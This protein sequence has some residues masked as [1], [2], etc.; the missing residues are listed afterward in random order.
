M[1]ALSI[2]REQID[3]L[4]GVPVEQTPGN[5]GTASRFEKGRRYTPNLGFRPRRFA[6]L[7]HSYVRPWGKTADGISPRAAQDAI[8]SGCRS[9]AFSQSGRLGEKTRSTIVTGCSTSNMTG[10]EA[11]AISSTVA[12]A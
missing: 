5:R 11:S 6:D 2:T 1:P 3:A 10:S 4:L 9:R 12:A 7:L 8:S